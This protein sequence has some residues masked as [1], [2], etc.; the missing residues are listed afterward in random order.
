M[1]SS[2]AASSASATPGI[3]QAAVLVSGKA[4]PEFDQVVEGYDFNKGLDFPGIMKSFMTTGF[5]ATNFGLA[6]NEVNRMVY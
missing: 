3:A 1:A 4:L 2:A 5:Q 6:V